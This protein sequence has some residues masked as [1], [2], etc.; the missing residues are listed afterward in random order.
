SLLYLVNV[1]DV[2]IRENIRRIAHVNDRQSHA[3]KLVRVEQY[4]EYSRAELESPALMHIQLAAH[5][6]ALFDE[7]KD[8]SCDIGKGHVGRPTRL[9]LYSK[10]L[11][12]QIRDL[13]LYVRVDDVRVA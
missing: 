13:S 9:G 12:D 8:D 5:F 7:F 2:G 4:P 11:L 3:V 10:V 1:R 6:I